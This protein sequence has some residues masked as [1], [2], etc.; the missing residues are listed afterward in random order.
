MSITER[1]EQLKAQWKRFAEEVR[2]PG[3]CI[4]CAGCTIW[5]NGTRQRS[6]SVLVEGVAVYLCDVLCRRVKCGNRECRKSW[7][8][9]PPGL[10]PQRHYQLCLTAEGLSDYLFNPSSSLEKVA[11]ACQCSMRTV[12]R[13][14]NWTASLADAQALERRILESAGH[15]V[16][17]PLRAISDRFRRYCGQGHQRVL[18]RAGQN[19]CFLESLCQAR[20]LEPPGLR[21]VLSA[22]VAN[23]Y[24]L[25][26]YR[27]PIIP[28]FAWR[29][30]M[31]TWP[32]MAS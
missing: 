9:R 30:W 12:G 15:P 28:D 16:L 26:T 29:S 14:V 8:L 11:R 5:W 20:G 7:T 4:F 21:G 13:W 19:L 10:F 18:S 27:A 31:E 23:R 25:T 3:R 17:A 24:R 22:V 1:V 32:I 2:K 6:A